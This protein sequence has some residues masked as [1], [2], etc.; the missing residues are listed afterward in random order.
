MV[1]TLS[2]KEQLA[3]T[4]AVNGAI[5]VAEYMQRC[6]SH[7][8]ATRDPFGAQGDF[9]TA[10][11]I[12]Q[13]FGEL[14]GAW[15]QDRWQHLSASQA[16]LCEVGPGRGTLMRDM[17]R[18]TR[19]SGLHESVDVRLIETSPVLRELQLRNL[20]YAHS[21][22][23]WHESLANLP[24]LPLFLVANEFFDALPVHQYLDKEERKI[25][26]VMNQLAF[27]PDGKVTYEASPVSTHIMTQIATHI[28]TYGGAAL[29]IDYG[30]DGEVVY[31]DSLQALKAHKYIHPLD[32][33]GESDITAHVDFT[34]LKS[35]ALAAGGS[36][37]GVVEQ[38]E[39]LMRL[40][41]Q[42][43]ADALCNNAS[44]EQQ[45]AIRAGVERLVSR[46][47]MGR[48]F[49]VMAVTSAEDK[50]PGF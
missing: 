45:K 4:I 46:E 36:V 33:P 32:E 12:S 9:I 1:C 13:V 2:L 10:P 29:V 18:V 40:G 42:L 3:E 30:Y 8:Y 35:A 31:S 20:H 6:G 39:F 16:V 28:K 49:K 34:S 48:L 37:W 26:L 5:S 22:I 23:N 43:R 15:M 19:H 47:Q 41:A 25:G 44:P 14:I 17:L 21:R 24:P 11:E 38:G 27:M 7:Y 50:P